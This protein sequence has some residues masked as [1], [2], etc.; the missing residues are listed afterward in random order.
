MN[1][2]VKKIA[3]LLPP[4]KKR[5]QHII[6]LNKFIEDLKNHNEALAKELLETQFLNKFL[7]E[8]LYN[9]VDEKKLCPLCNKEFW[10]Y[11]P[12]G[13]IP[14]KNARCPYCGSLERYRAWY[15]FFNNHTNI[16]CNPVN[17]VKILHFAAEGFIYEK[18]SVLT[19]VDYYPVDIDPLG[20]GGVEGIRDV[21]DI[22]KIKYP[23]NM[24]DII[25][26]NH[27]LEHVQDDIIAIKELYRVLKKSGIA[28]INS[29]VF[30]SLEFTLE[31]PEYNTPEL[32][33]QYYGQHDHLRKYGMDYISRLESAGF[34]VKVILPNEIFNDSELSR[35]GLLKDEKIYQCTIN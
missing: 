3:L 11:L 31:K 32:R 9:I 8:Q 35:Y 26:C 15:L 10:T 17:E 25:I 21:I 12:F 24:F 7:I 28:Y 30:D 16:F 20:G 13:E 6:D 4:V 22:Q 23:D 34:S 33:L 27:V 2:Y 5:Y 1:K 14:R 19:N 18:L 29:P